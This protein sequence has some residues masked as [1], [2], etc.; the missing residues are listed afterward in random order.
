MSTPVIALTAS[1]MRQDREVIL[2]YGFD[3][4]IAK[5]IIEADFFRI[6]QEVLYGE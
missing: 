5:P 6:I 1:A 3:G 4:F 2:A